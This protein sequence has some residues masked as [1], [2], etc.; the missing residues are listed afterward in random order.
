M[1]RTPKS[2]EVQYLLEEEETP[3]SAEVVVIVNPNEC[4]ISF[5]GIVV[6]PKGSYT[7]T[8]NDLANEKVM[9][10]INHGLITGFITKG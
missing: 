8:E 3:K 6:E 2:A 10:Q 1:A 7:L 9:K 4:T 5:G